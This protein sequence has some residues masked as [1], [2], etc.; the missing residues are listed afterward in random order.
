MTITLRFMHA[1]LFTLLFFHGLD[2]TTVN[3]FNVLSRSI[4][5]FASLAFCWCLEAR[6]M[7]RERTH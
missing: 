2:E 4:A 7:G 3:V 5:V 1:I 6:C